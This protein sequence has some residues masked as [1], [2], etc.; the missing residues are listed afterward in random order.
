[1]S[2][3]A[4]MLVPAVI[5]VFPGELIGLDGWVFQRVPFLTDSG[6]PYLDFLLVYAIFYHI[7]KSVSSFGIENPAYY[8]SIRCVIVVWPSLLLALYYAIFTIDV[9]LNQ[10]FGLFLILSSIVAYSYAINDKF[11][12]RSIN[13]I[14]K[15]FAFGSI[16]SALLAFS[17]LIHVFGV[18][19]YSSGSIVII[20][21]F[22]GEDYRLRWAAV[23]SVEKMFVAASVTWSVYKLINTRN[24]YYLII[25]LVFVTQQAVQ[26]S[27][28]GIL[29]VFLATLVPIFIF[30]P[31]NKF[32]SEY[33]G[34]IKI[35]IVSLLVSII[36]LLASGESGQALFRSVGEI[37]DD[38]S[39][40]SRMHDA[41]MD[42]FTKNPYFGA[43]F[44]DLYK[45]QEWAPF[46]LPNML[47]PIHNFFVFYMVYFGVFGLA[48]LVAPVLLMLRDIVI[49]R[50]LLKNVNPGDDFIMMIGISFS[51]AI[52]GLYNIWFQTMDRI[53]FM[54]FW[55]VCAIFFRGGSALS[56]S[57]SI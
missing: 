55:A 6:I 47:L 9:V 34:W 8:T 49:V 28:G 30:P 36:L 38:E 35:F 5:S 22:D 12:M 1:M 13:L 39:I 43:G 25:P 48:L 10:A 4:L 45:S 41:A 54:C 46:I 31:N 18:V 33:I 7:Y 57:R 44:F 40:R 50:R 14:N 26:S 19:S 37:S 20:D 15:V 32:I 27:R 51:V 24:F 23:R 2:K 11:D 42:I 29:L 52:S 53:S 17:L 3:I 16:F 21:R 56:K